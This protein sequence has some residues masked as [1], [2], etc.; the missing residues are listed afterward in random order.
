MGRSVANAAFLRALL[1]ADPFDEYHFLLRD[2]ALAN[3]VRARLA[4][5]FP[6][7]AR[8]G[9]LV[10]RER[11][12]LPA[13]MADTPFHC[14]HLS[15]CINHPAHLAA[16]RNAL[17]PRI[18]PI[19]GPT[20]SLSYRRFSTDFL[21]QL[22][23]GSTR[24][25]CVIA[26]STTAVEVVRGFHDYLSE[27]YGIAPECRPRVER[28]PLGVDTDVYRP[29]TQEERRAARE[30][31]GLADG[32]LAVLLFSR[33]SHHSKM[34]PL[35]VLRAF[36]RLGREGFDL[37]RVVLCLAGW[38]D[39]DGAAFGATLAELARNVGLGWRLEVGPD[40]S[41]KRELFWACDVF[42]SPVDNPQETFGL[43][44]LEA[45]AMG[46]A[47][48]A[49][50][51]DGYRDL[52]VHGETGLLVPTLGPRTTDGV[53]RMAPLVF[54]ADYH[55]L[56]AQET[57][58]DVP[59]M[60]QALRTLF[61]DPALRGRLGEN[62]RRRV[63]AE[64]S[65]RS[66]V[67]RHVELWDALWNEPVDEAA[68]RGRRHPMQL[69]YARVFG[70]YPTG[71]LDDALRVTWSAA[72]RA[73]YRGQEFV[74]FYEGMESRLSPERLRRVVF[75]ARKPIACARLAAKLA[76]AESMPPEDAEFCI[77]WALKNDF[78]ER[79]DER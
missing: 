41:R 7:L 19:T 37:S 3:G 24:R 10:F 50:D 28:I 56:L 54:D 43:T 65:W 75:F 22:W 40:E 13:A 42:L 71:V 57:V 33:L 79:C 16:L 27:G 76:E 15:D 39:G 8:G 74:S 61:D 49:S 70:G 60:A 46:C 68:L 58:V 64:F 48:V 77:L 52:V 14:M 45:G 47:V 35:P 63:E 31:L 32:Q 53:D 21:A 55:L 26:T 69:P 38:D 73:L 34:D 4:D 72:G 66:V 11:A 2:R 12:E 9:R 51:Y 62:A 6:E 1:R 23:P 59:R 67:E 44:M 18:F 29:A 30:S 5:E 78:L 20:H 17:S 36:Q 25:D